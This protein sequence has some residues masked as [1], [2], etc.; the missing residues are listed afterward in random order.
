MSLDSAKGAKVLLWRRVG[1]GG[2]VWRM[3]PRLTLTQR[4]FNAGRQGLGEIP[5]KLPLPVGRQ[6]A[7]GIAGRVSARGSGPALRSAAGLSAR[8]GFV[9]GRGMAAG[10]RAGPRPA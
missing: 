4:G 6:R 5:R 10:R 2:E 9:S 8:A 1:N 3:I 7:C